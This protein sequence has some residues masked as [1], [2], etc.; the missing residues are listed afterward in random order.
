MINMS[1]SFFFSF[2]FFFIIYKFGKCDVLSCRT[3]FG[4]SLVQIGLLPDFDDFHLAICGWTS[5]RIDEG[6]IVVQKRLRRLT[7]S[8]PP[9]TIRRSRHHHT[10][11]IIIL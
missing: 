5:S 3:N 6:A 8:S 11:A 2:I 4:P 1:F 9:S 7:D 10:H